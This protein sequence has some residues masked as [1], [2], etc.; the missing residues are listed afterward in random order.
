MFSTRSKVDAELNRVTLAFAERQRRGEPILDLTLSNPTVAGLPYD[1]GVVLESIANERALIY[2]PEPFGLLEAREAVCELYRELGLA[3]HASRT[4]LTTST[5]EAY[6]FAFKLLCDA[7]DDV[8]VP[9]P[10]YPLLEHLATIE[11]I[12]IRPYQLRYDGAWSLDIDSVR[13]AL[14]PRT[15]AIVVV[16]PNN[17]TG[18]FLTRGELVQLFSLGLPV[19]SDEVFGRYAFEDDSERVPSVLEFGEGL[20]LVLDGLSKRAG[21]P[22]LKLAWMTLAG[23][24]ALVRDAL[25]RLELIADTFLSPATPVQLALSA[26]LRA[27]RVTA[28]AILQRVRRNYR[29]LSALLRDSPAS[30]LRADG[31]WYAVLR[32]PR[33]LS[34]EDWVLGFLDDGVWVQP[35]YFYDFASEAFVVLSLLTPEATFDEGVARLSRVCTERC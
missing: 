16:Q 12:G 35:G 5:S 13:R 4:V 14:T 3:V 15:R 18:S 21:L 8:L 33:T 29:A 31:G 27:G 11:Q 30:A 25:A 9:A 22:Q 32:L 7:G 24:G 26:L 28:Q 1:S 34:E 6:S 20:C 17:P 23:Q 10:S 19:I 2:A